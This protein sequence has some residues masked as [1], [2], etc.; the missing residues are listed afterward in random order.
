M[1]YAIYRFGFITGV[2][3]GD[4]LLSEGMPLFHADT[5]FS[6]LYIEALKV[7]KAERL[8]EMVSEGELRF[9]DAL[10]Y[11]RGD[12]LVPKPMVAVEFSGDNVVA[13]RKQYKKLK[14]LPAGRIEN[15]LA[16]TL[17]PRQNGLHAFGRLAR[18]TKAWVRREED[19]L[20]FPVGVFYYEPDCGVYC[21]VGY[22]AEEERLLAEELLTML[23]YTGIGGKR[24]SG[25]GKFRLVA[26]CGDREMSGRLNGR[27]SRYMLMSVALP[28]E[29]EM[30]KAL[31]G[32]SYLLQKRSGFVYSDSY[33]EKSEKKRDLY[34][35][36]AGSCF[37]YPFEGGVYDV[38][39][40][41]A[42]PVYRYARPM[43][44]L[45]D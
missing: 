40:G 10:P 36:A 1:K 14:Y 5:L 22:G 35:F 15:Y 30:E 31:S 16:G 12:Y 18:Q 28:G 39:A 29:Q 27:G 38:S 11:V 24:S 23:S 13:Q 43:F 41:G 9:S 19:T 20:P 3:F 7:G 25:L 21:I 37:E 26:G 8:F 6:A 42:H 44:L 17:D 2:H 4:G 34:L 45:L 33:S 32:A